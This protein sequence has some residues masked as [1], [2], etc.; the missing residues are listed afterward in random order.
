M[1]LFISWLQSLATP[2]E[3]PNLT[4]GAACPCAEPVTNSSTATTTEYITASEAAQQDEGIG[5]SAYIFLGIWMVVLYHIAH[6]IWLERHR[7]QQTQA[8]HQAGFVMY[9]TYRFGHWYAW[10][11]AASVK[12]LLVLSATLLVVGGIGHSA[13]SQ[14]SI[15]ES[16]WRSWIW[17]A[18]PDGG[19]SAL[20]GGHA[21]GVV[22]SIGGMLIFALLLS[23]ITSAFEDFLWQIRHGSIPV[24]EGDHIVILGYE[25]SAIWMI[26]ELCCAMETSGGG[27]IAILSTE[28]KAEVESWIQHADIDLRNSSVVVRSGLPYN[29][30]DL[31]RV[32]VQT[33]RRIVVLANRKISREE[34]D[35]QTLNVLLTLQGLDYTNSKDRCTIVEC[36]L[37]RNQNLFRSLA[38]G[39][40][41]VLATQDF[42]GQLLVEA[43]RQR[44]LSQVISQ[45]LGFE[46]MEFYIAEV[47][48]IEGWTFGDLLFALG[49]SIPIGYMDH[50]QAV[51]V[52]SME[53]IFSGHEQLICLSEDASTLA[54]SISPGTREKVLKRRR[55]NQMKRT[56][57]PGTM[58]D[59]ATPL[60]ETIT[61]IIGWNEGIGS[62]VHEVDQAVG[63]DSTVL[64][65]SPQEADV[66]EEYLDSCQVR[67]NYK[68]QNV[69][70]EHVEGALGARYKL[71]D[72]PLE[73]AQKIFILADKMSNCEDEAD[74]LTVA[75][76]L[77][78]RDILRV[79]KTCQTDLVI[80]PQVLGRRAEKNC[81]KSGLIDYINSNRLACQVLAQ[82]CQ[83]PNICCVFAELL[84]G[85]TARIC[86]RKL[87]D[88]L[89]EDETQF[90]VS[91]K[92]SGDSHESLKVTFSG[93]QNIVA[94]AGEVAI[95]WSR[96][97]EKLKGHK[98]I[99][100]QMIWELNP[101]QWE[102]ERS[103]SESDMIVV[104]AKPPS[105]LDDGAAASTSPTSPERAGGSH[106][107]TAT[108]VTMKAAM[109]FRKVLR[110]QS[111][112]WSASG[113][114]VGSPGD[115]APTPFDGLRGADSE[116]SMSPHSVHHA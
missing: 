73:K 50:G 74:R 68:Y 20:P 23:L 31:T 19:E 49:Q 62:I 70:V 17:I 21:V 51:L 28:G 107:V 8:A 4:A 56:V 12:V 81:W 104:V 95:G 92:R 53:Y 35:A 109:K 15:Q 110:K 33:A 78:V 40:M 58:K 75:T 82:V 91:P 89:T 102:E 65:Y 71:E 77:Q 90:P 9:L 76:L 7:F 60:K 46:G 85:N 72:L 84:L 34:A 93:I 22:V 86:I 99:E 42:L 41:Q 24:V 96:A 43:S 98:V 3:A 30:E 11:Q 54:K 94:K 18:D 103:W 115:A 114:D 27:L 45:T 59:Q 97:K 83:S 69:T 61:V 14:A 48:G 39:P 16:L 105:L 100:G 37:V 88:Y 13:L 80:L 79:R 87:S 66:R 44:G 111:S 47:H 32:A 2:E 6:I 38:S 63:A 64:I 36:C 1:E 25:R 5:V 57:S 112:F 106:G 26:E 55:A 52:P 10:T 108:A 116:S 113:D 67:L 29:E 101:A